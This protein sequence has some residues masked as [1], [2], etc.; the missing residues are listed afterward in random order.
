MIKYSKAQAAIMLTPQGRNAELVMATCN[1]S[2]AINQGK[3]PIY[4][5]GNKA[6]KAPKSA[7]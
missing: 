3:T 7:S 1:V 5:K 2:D 6:T 4:S